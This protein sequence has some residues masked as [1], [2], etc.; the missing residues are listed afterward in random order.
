[1]REDLAARGAWA[2]VKP[3]PNRR[4]VAAFSSFLYRYRKTTARSR[5]YRGDSDQGAVLV[6]DLTRAN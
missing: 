1:M 4:R 6:L 2:N 3:M 5:I